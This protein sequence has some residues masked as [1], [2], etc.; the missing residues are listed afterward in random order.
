[1]PVDVGAAAAFPPLRLRALAGALPAARA[2]QRGDARPDR[3]DR[4]DRAPD[5]LRARLRALARLPAAPLRAEGLPLLHRVRR[6]ASSRSSR[7]SRRSLALVG[8]LSR[9]RRRPAA[10]ARVRDLRRDARCR[11][12]SARSPIHYHLNPWLVLSHFLLSLVVL[13]SAWSLAA[14]GDCDSRGA[15]AAR[16]A[17]GCGAAASLVA[18]AACVLIVSGTLATAAGSTRHPGSTVVRRLWSFQPAVYWHVR[19]T[20]VFGISFAL[21]LVWLVRNA[22]PRTCAAALVVLGAARR[23]DGDRRD[24]V[25]HAPAVVARAR[26]R[27]RSPRRVWAAV[28]AFVVRLWRPAAPRRTEPMTDELRIDSRPEPR[29]PGP[30]R[31]VPRLER[32]RPG[33]VARRRVSRAARGRREQ[34]AD[35][36]SGGLL[37]L[38]GDAADGL[39][40]RR[41]DAADR[42]AGEHVP[43]RAAAR[44]RPRRDDPA[45]RRA[46]PP[47]AHVQRAR[48]RARDASSTS[49]SW[50]RSARCSPTCRTR[51]PRR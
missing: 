22:Q 51:G 36:R 32:R 37:R 26:A 38:P 19:A 43:P 50:S 45:R 42:L 9:A 11:R 49:S 16:A 20:A 3:R 18:L 44:R 46:E 25:P 31:R 30:D 2:R 5:R 23:A 12:R 14:R 33:R 27:H 39:A 24:A 17:R 41:R 4:R 7:S 35:D 29:A 10:R 47:L 34:F 15:D 21:L 6:T 1:M 40:R 13:T 8:A 28:T 48:R